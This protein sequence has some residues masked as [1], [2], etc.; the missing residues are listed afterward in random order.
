VTPNHPTHAMSVQQ[1]VNGSEGKAD[2]GATT[3]ARRPRAALSI[4]RRPRD[5]IVLAIAGVVVTLCSWTAMAP[6][7]N[8]VELAIYQQ[9]GKIPTTSTPMWT[10]LAWTGSWVG[11]A[12]ATALALYLRR[13]RLGS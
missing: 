7:I 8:P 12:A 5:L 3:D 2:A 9:F 13:L 11:I 4:G 1:T 10:V 6:A